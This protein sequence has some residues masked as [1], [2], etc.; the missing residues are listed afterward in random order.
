MKVLILLLLLVGCT[1]APNGA[2]NH[3]SPQVSIDGEIVDT[4]PNHKPV[5]THYL[6]DTRGEIHSYK[7]P[8]IMH[9]Q[10]QLVQYCKNH[11]NWESIRAFWNPKTDE[12]E[13]LVR[14]KGN[15]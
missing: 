9:H 6:K 10:T 3:T 15:W 14:Q 2:F 4:W 5:D 12:Y 1:N 13:Y 8:V 11:K 7:L